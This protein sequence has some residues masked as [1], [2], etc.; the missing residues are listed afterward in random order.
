M[1]LGSEAAE[2]LLAAATAEKSGE[3]YYLTR[4]T[5]FLS[6]PA[7]LQ[8]IIKGWLP[9]N[10]TAMVF[11][12][13]GVGKTFVSLDLACCVATGTQWHDKKTASGTVVYLAG[14]GNYGIRQRVASWARAHDITNLDNLLI[15]NKSI[16][17][18]SPARPLR[19]SRP[20]GR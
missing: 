16:D 4:A 1:A 15:S 3:D 19:S 6:Q 8:W 17:M 14:E 12:E 5:S 13:S 20:S 11:G 10:C 18:D 2:A 7:P 9:A